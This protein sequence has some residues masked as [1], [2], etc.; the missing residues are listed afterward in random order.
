MSSKSKAAPA[1]SGIASPSS[2]SSAF[3]SP[4][5]G[6][7]GRFLPNAEAAALGVNDGDGRTDDGSSLGGQKFAFTKDRQ[8]GVTGAVFLILNK[9]IGTGSEF[10]PAFS[11]KRVAWFASPKLLRNL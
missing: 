10:S 5:T 6:S 1:G 4:N 3:E 2:D 8:I 11:M 7:H 9:M